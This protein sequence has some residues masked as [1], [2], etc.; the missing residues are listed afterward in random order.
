MFCSQLRVV[1]DLGSNRASRDG[2]SIRWSMRLGASISRK[3]RDSEIGIKVIRLQEIDRF[4]CAQVPFVPRDFP[5]QVTDDQL[6]ISSQRS[7]IVIIRP[8]HVE[9]ETL[10][11]AELSLEPSPFAVPLMQITNLRFR[12]RHP[13]VLFLARVPR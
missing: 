6:S 9:P 4:K 12:L 7:S 3:F 13:V 2:F 10:R 5:F 8:E 1:H 11:K